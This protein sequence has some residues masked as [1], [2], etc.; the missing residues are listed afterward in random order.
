VPE[1]WQVGDC[2]A[3]RIESAQSARKVSKIRT[4][5]ITDTLH[6]VSSYCI[7]GFLGSPDHDE[8]LLLLFSS[9]CYFDRELSKPGLWIIWLN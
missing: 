4:V 8:L 3:A 5:F 2:A 9:D 7:T 1:I 6:L